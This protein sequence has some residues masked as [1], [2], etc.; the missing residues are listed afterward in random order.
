MDT[1]PALVAVKALI[2]ITP[3]APRPI[4]GLLFVQLAPVSVPATV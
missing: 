3:E 2:G 4:A 1:V